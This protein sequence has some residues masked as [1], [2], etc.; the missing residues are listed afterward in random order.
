[1]LAGLAQPRGEFT[2]VVAGAMDEPAVAIR[3][4][5]PPE[6]LNEFGRLTNDAGLSRREAVTS[7]AARLGLP[8]RE[9][10]RLIE[11]AKKERA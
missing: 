8:S 11:A 5:D 10:Y 3:P 6:L 7:L 4:P 2:V 1:V 9:L